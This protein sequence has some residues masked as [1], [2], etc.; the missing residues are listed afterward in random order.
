MGGGRPPRPRRPPP[1][2]PPPALSSQEAELLSEVNLLTERLADVE[3]T[4]GARG[5]ALAAPDAPPPASFVPPSPRSP[6]R[7]IDRPAG[8]DF[9]RSPLLSRRSAGGNV[10]AQEDDPALPRRARALLRCRAPEVRAEVAHLTVEAEEL[11]VEVEALAEFLTVN[12]TGFRKALKKQSKVT[13]GIPGWAAPP[14]LDAMMP[15]IDKA[16]DELPLD[17]LADAADAIVGAHAVLAAGGS[18]AAATADLRAKLRDA[19]VIERG[20]VWQ[21]MV[22]RER[23]TAAA[24]VTRGGERPSAASGRRGAVARA[25]AAAALLGSSAVFFA[26]LAAPIF[27]AHPEKRNCLAILAFVSCLWTTEAM[28]LFATSMLVPGLVIGLRVMVDRTVD[29]P[30]RLAPAAAAPVVFGAMMSQVVMLLLGGFAMAAALSKHY[31]AKWAAAAVLGRVGDAPAALLLASMCVAVVASA[32]ISNVAAPVLVYSL[33]EPVLR[34]LPAGRHGE[35]LARALVLGVALASNLGG[36]TSPIASPQNVFAIERM[37]DAAGEAPSWLAWFA[38]SLPVAGV[39]VLAC[40]GAL[41]VAYPMARAAPVRSLPS[42]QSSATGVQLYVVAVCAGTVAL[43]C[44]N[45]T[46]APVVGGM[47]VTALLPLVAFFGTGVLTK[48]DFN[49]MLWTVVM[50]AMGG[51]ALGAAVSSSGLLHTV[52][53]AAAAASHGLSPWA[54]HALFCSLVLVATTF[55]SHTVGAMVILPIVEAVGRA[56]L[57][58]AHP[59]LLVMGAALTCSAAMGLPVSGFPNMAAA[60]LEAADGRAFLST[61]DF[62]RVGVPCSLVAYGVIVTL[63]YRLMTGANG[64]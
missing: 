25:G 12:R 8:G 62:I 36:M 52:A 9:L 14:T 13:R 45:A 50:L 22:A 37:A 47:G 17:P 20:T 56:M 44:A 39:G 3:G 35:D 26:L 16:F 64:W 59:R 49:S 4:A 51:L 29:P 42:S 27:P 54:T 46:L 33:L 21:D 5:P 48:D 58:Q 40:W 63:G 38:V 60:S 34:T 55:V 41:L 10:E 28:P 6:R 30:V 61:A 7:S 32:F 53:R 1:D 24:R 57:P 23:R 11:F 2:H 31:V 15:A 19:L 43:W 18:T